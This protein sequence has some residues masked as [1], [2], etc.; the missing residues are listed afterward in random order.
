[1]PNV[2]LWGYGKSG[3]ETASTT[4]SS[5]SIS[6]EA[7][8]G[9]TNTVATPQQPAPFPS[10]E[11]EAALA[12]ADPTTQPDLSAISDLVNSADEILS[13]PEGLGYLSSLGMDYGWGP[14]SMMQWLLEHIH[15]WGGMGWAG[16]ICATAVL[17]RLAMFYPTIKSTR[18]SAR[19]KGMQADPRFKEVQK[20][21]KA[22]M[23]TS[24]RQG[25]S[26]AQALNG[27]LR[28]EYNVPFAEMGW[29]FL[30][31]PFSYGLFRVVTG[32]TH[33]PV[34]AMEHSGFLWFTDLTAT[35]PFMIL[36]AAASALMV[37]AIK[38]SSKNVSVSLRLSY[39][40]FIL[41]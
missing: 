4:A 33:I 20:K 17:L 30:P 31:I 8:A 35:D 36:P 9:T 12:S 18:F 25:I 5:D 15:V 27:I 34:P 21:L 7:A 1:M 6:A 41:F 26:E 13:R 14:S 28:R 16:S 39:Y 19:M 23:G 37:V 29:A 2:S 32:M 10:P 24:D 3:N 40:C 38:V 22:S 11:A